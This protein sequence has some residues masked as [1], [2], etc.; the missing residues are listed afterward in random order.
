METKTLLRSFKD[1]ALFQGRFSIDAYEE[2]VVVHDGKNDQKATIPVGEPGHPVK[3]AFAGNLRVNPKLPD[4]LGS[5][6]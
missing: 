6:G 5:A 4:Q 3:G 1:I 2:G